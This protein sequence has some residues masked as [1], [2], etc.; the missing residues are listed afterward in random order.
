MVKR[1]LG[2]LYIKM[3]LSFLATCVLFFAGLAFFWNDYFTDF[4]Y[5]DKKA[6]LTARAAEVGRL[7]ASVQDGS[8]TAKELRF[9][10]RII[11]RGINGTA[12]LV[13]TKG[14]LL[15]GSSEKEGTAIPK[16][17]EPLLL[18]GLKG[19]TAFVADQYPF[20][21]GS[22]EGLLTYY[23]PAQHQGQPIVIML[24]VPAYEI[25]EA[26]KAVRW[27][28]LS[29]LL[30]SLVAVGLILYVLS[31]KLTGP[32]QQMNKA[33]LEVAGGEFTTR[34]PISTDD[35]VGE[36]ARSFNFMIDQLEEWEGT[37][38]EFLTNVSH[39]LRSPLTTLR[40]LILAMKD[41]VIPEDK[42]SHYLEIC[43]HEVQ[44]L[45]RLVSDL[46]DL[47]RIQNGIDVF[48]TRPVVL[49]EKVSE[50]LEL[51]NKPIADKGLQLVTTLPSEGREPLSAE[52]DPDRFAQILQNL[53][54]NAVQFTPAGGRIQVE[55]TS[56]DGHTALLKVRDTG[57]GMSEE[58]LHR[59]WDR[60]YKAEHSRVSRSDGTGLGLTIVKHLVGGMKGT[61]SVESE[62]GKGTEFTVAFPT[63][64]KEKDKAVIRA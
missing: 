35:E 40:G 13:D 11:A 44:R 9:G 47:A 7:L 20:G 59:I 34:V 46:L 2:S 58:E 36:L 16:A 5:K 6:M 22:K 12:W 18:D 53:L 1:L 31:R 33:A 15:Y 4:F 48:R 32:L 50:V 55:L 29:P 19:H 37:R 17:M 28:I 43:E 54:Y 23:A 56:D 8:V 52:L 10:M 3:F 30:F 39:E 64:P 24:Q 62:I 14:T 21:S 25:N 57:V 45:Q 60:F 41:R 51:M 49:K 26:I 38:Q 61:I 42:Y 27:N 63:I